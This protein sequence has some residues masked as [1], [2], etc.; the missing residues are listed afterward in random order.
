MQSGS[1]YVDAKFQSWRATSPAELPSQPELAHN[2]SVF[3]YRHKRLIYTRLGHVE[4][5]DA[6]GQRLGDPFGDSSGV[7]Q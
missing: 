1:S 3:S 5:T 4:Y 7:E 2:L 6:D